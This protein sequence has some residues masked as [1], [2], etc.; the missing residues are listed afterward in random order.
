M[1]EVIWRCP[2]LRTEEE[3]V[4]MDGWFRA[5]D[6]DLREIR[7]NAV[8]TAGDP[9]QLHV[10]VFQTNEAGQRYAD[11][12]AEQVVTLPRVVPLRWAPPFLPGNSPAADPLAEND[13]DVATEYQ[14]T[15]HDTA[16][17][18]SLR[19]ALRDSADMAVRVGGVRPG[20]VLPARLTHDA[21]GPYAL[22]DLAGHPDTDQRVR[23]Q[24]RYPG[25]DP[26]H[27]VLVPAGGEG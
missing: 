3:L 13:G 1:R 27:L 7:Q 20:L 10:S 8:I 11:L 9:P 2:R 23:Y 16:R 25:A 14:L 12:A 26:G 22:V 6:I 24:R 19:S 15:E 21:V 18:N 4:V 17:I 5:H